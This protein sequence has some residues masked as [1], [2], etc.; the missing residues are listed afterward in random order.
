MAS[1]ATL[2]SHFRRCLPTEHGERLGDREQVIRE[3]EEELRRQVAEI[4]DGESQWQEMQV[5]WTTEKQQAE[6][7]IRDL[8]KQ[9]GESEAA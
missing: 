3:K 1:S 2:Y 8:L 9:L 6:L 5:R 4:P 7:I